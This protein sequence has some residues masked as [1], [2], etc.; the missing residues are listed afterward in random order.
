[1]ADLP[2]L[3]RIFDG[4]ATRELSQSRF[5]P[6]LGMV[7]DRLAPQG[8]LRTVCGY[9]STGCGL[10]VHLQEGGAV[11]LSPD[12]DY[13]VNLGAACPKGWEAMA[14]LASPDRGTVPLLRDPSTGRMKPVSWER[15]LEVFVEKLR[16]ALSRHGSDGAAFLST[17]QIPTEEMLFLGALWKFGIGATAADSNTRQCMATAHTAYK[18]SFGFDAPPFTYADFEESDSLVF[19]G[20]NPAIAHPILWERVLKNRRNPTIVVLDPRRTETAQAATRHVALAPKS[21]LV[22]L[23]ALARELIQRGRV[24]TAFVEAHTEGFAS[25]ANFLQEFPRER[26]L[27]EAGISA[28]EFA[29]LA[30][31][32]EPGKR[33][34][35]WWTMGVNQSHQAVRTAQAIVNLCLMTGNIGKPGTGPNSIT[36]QMNAMGSRLFSC[37]SSLPGGRDWTNAS[38]RG[39]IA[40]YFGIPASGIPSSSGPAYD[41]IL[42]KA[43]NGEMGFLWVVATN[44]AHSWIGQRD[45]AQ[46]A[47]KT[48]LVVQDMY[49]DTETA[50]M[51]DLY[52]PSGGW[53]EKDGSIINSERR[54]GRMRR[55][56]TPPGQALSDLDIF[57][58]VARAWGVGGRIGSWR[59]A[60]DLFHAM[61]DLSR[62]RPCDISGV[63]NLSAL[64]LQGGVQWPCPEGAY[65][66]AKERRLFGDGRF[67]TKSGKARFVFDPPRPSPNALSATFPLRMLTGRGSSSQWHT[68]TRTS[69]SAVLRSLS[70]ADP[71]V[72]MHPTDAA[73]RD[74]VQ[75][76]W[77]R[78]RSRKGVARARVVVASTMRPGEVFVPMH[79]PDAN[80]LTEPVFDP[81]SRQPSYKDGAVEVERDR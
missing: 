15:A 54:L 49:P 26:A 62:G 14:P 66:P 76:D 1:L 42:S 65:P 43:G 22:L 80:Q 60:E 36:G 3:V 73:A 13:P 81:H 7:P 64:E 38:H 2:N 35:I 37:T 46:A 61:R 77:V 67:F 30:D 11:N 29:F 56:A 57:R 4:P 45:F 17:G 68:L 70:P 39:E 21:D 72:E 9:C 23:Y 24:D 75:G 6:G 52:L 69:R 28:E 19:V 12:P 50:G 48:F 78:I 44:P 40:E 59:T 33:V 31:L 20:A 63:E 79:A 74:L 47:E 53:G 16:E 18:D 41:Q 5:L 34:S 25:F 10:L 27:E 58:L 51:A 55:A 8:L 71:V 32:F